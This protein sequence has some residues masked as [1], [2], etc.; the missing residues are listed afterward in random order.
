MIGVIF[1][2]VPEDGVT[3]EWQRGGDGNLG[4]KF[5]LFV[6]V[7]SETK[8]NHFWNKT[9]VNIF[10]TICQGQKDWEAN[11]LVETMLT[12]SCK[13]KAESGGRIVFS[14]VEEDS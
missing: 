5:K 13:G 3:E 14:E 12:S 8:P 7:G 4:K 10:D 6:G 9:I 1:R 11:L 2:K